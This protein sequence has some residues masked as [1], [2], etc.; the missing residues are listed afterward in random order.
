MELLPI[1]ELKIQTLLPAG[2]PLTWVYLQII[3]LNYLRL[4]TGIWDNGKC[5]I[6]SVINL[7]NSLLR[8]FPPMKIRF[9]PI[10]PCPSTVIHSLLQ[11][12]TEIETIQEMLI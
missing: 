6:S 9:R 5:C 4:G 8:R 1:M 12:L 2:M 3:M 7:E 11:L 10:H